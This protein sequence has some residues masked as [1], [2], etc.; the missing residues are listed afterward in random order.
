MRRNRKAEDEGGGK[1]WLTSYADLMSV[2][3]TFFILMF[4]M[5]TLEEVRLVQ[6]LQ[7]FG[8][9]L[10]NIVQDP[11]GDGV[12]DFASGAIGLESAYMIS[13]YEGR[14]EEQLQ[15]GGEVSEYMQALVLEF[16]THFIQFSNPFT[17]LGF[18][19]AAERDG[20]DQATAGQTGYGIAGVDVVV[21]DE[22]TVE[23][24]FTDG[25]LFA[26]GSAT[27]LPEVLDVLSYIAYLINEF[28][29]FEIM[30][31]GHTDNVPINTPVFPDN[32]RLSSARA[33]AVGLYFIYNH[34]IPPQ[35][36]EMRGRGEHQPIATNET[37]G[38]RAANRRV[39]ILIS[40]I[41]E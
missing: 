29:M 9:P 19:T 2:L 14:Y 36:V 28:P 18:G 7:S 22:H 31:T 30:I 21:L 5:S 25:V 32:W 27:L 26:S 24:T 33:E 13:P 1:E 39:E 20:S 16:E 10:I 23:I 37:V 12:D 8:N 4:S 40:E 3:F 38:G 35:R 15:H 11:T 6:F 41:I 17:H 34:G